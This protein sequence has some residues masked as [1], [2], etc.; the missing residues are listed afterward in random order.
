MQDLVI[1][2]ASGFGKEVAWL[3]EEINRATP[4][5]NLLGFLDD[6]PARHGSSSVGYPVLGPL[7][8]MQSHSGVASAIGIGEPRVRRR[9]ANR[10]AAFGAWFP[11]LVHPDVRLHPSVRVSPGVLICAGNILTVE[12]DLG[13]H[14]HVN[15]SNT[16]GH[17]AVL[18]DFCTIYPGNSISGDIVLEAGVSLGTGGSIIQGR[19][20]GNG[21]T[22]GAGATI[23]R[24]L[25]PD[26][27]AVGSPAK[28][29]RE[30]RPRWAEAD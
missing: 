17:G 25:P 14:A 4:T 18:G 21:T 11:A 20:V 15:L 23:V 16:I 19:R 7:D 10:A 5:W 3:V 26:V 28:P 12:I 24:D 30:L 1:I 2:G 9:V 8:W 27:V 29:I 22:V 6:D 13:Q